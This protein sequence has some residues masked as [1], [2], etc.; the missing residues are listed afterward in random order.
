MWRIIKA[1]GQILRA[2]IPVIACMEGEVAVFLVLDVGKNE[3]I[4]Y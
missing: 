2:R 1:W 3:C 4:M